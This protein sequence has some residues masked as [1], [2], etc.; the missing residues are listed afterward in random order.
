MDR[1]VSDADAKPDRPA[2]VEE[3]I[4]TLADLHDEHYDRL[5]PLGRAL[6]AVTANAG[7]PAFVI[8]LGIVAVGWIALNLT[9][10]ATGHAPPD[11]PPFYYLATATSLF[12]ALMTCLI[13]S[14]QRREDQLSTRR[15]QLTLEL[16]LLAE[17][18]VSKAIQLLEELRRD[19]P[20]I[21]DRR[22]DDAETLSTPS[23]ARMILD[24]IVDT[25]RDSDA[26]DKAD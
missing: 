18:K 11:P 17:Q 6:D 10:G 22:D 12:A 9:I 20:V 13:L 26:G 23:D 4:R 14:T 15:E 8:A 2:H 3:S 25:H 16:S 5:P 24:A 1:G 7:R 19:S 21:A